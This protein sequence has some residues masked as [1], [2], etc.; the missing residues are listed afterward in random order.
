MII[1]KDGNDFKIKAE[2]STH[3][4]WNEHD[5]SSIEF[6]K[7]K[8]DFVKVEKVSN[9][10]DIKKKSLLSENSLYYTSSEFIIPKMFRSTWNIPSN[11]KT[12]TLPI[13]DQTQDFTVDWGDGSELSNSLSHEYEEEGTYEVI[14]TGDGLFGF[15]PFNTTHNS[16]LVSIEDWGDIKVHN[17]G[18]QFY[19][20]SNLVDLGNIDVSHVTN[21]S[22]M[23]IYS[24]SF[25][26][27]LSSWDVSNVTNMQSMFQVA[28]S[29]NSDISD[30]DVSN[31][32]SMSRMFF[33][34]TSFN[35]DISNWDVS[36][37]NDM[38]YMFQGAKSFDSDISDWNVSN[39]TRMSFMFYYATSFNRDI[40][41][42]NV[43]NV[44]GMSY[45]FSGATS[46]N[47]DIG[48]WDVSK[49]TN[50]Q[51]MFSSASNFNQD[52][53]GW[54]V[55]NVTIMSQMFQGATSFNRDISDWNVSNV[56]DM[57]NMLNEVTLSTDN[58][59]SLLISWSQQDVQPNVNFHGGNSKYSSASENAR[60]ILVDKG[61]TINDGGK[62]S[63]TFVSTWSIQENDLSLIL[64]ITN[65]TQ[66][67]TVDWGD[68]SEPDT[69]KGHMYVEEGVYEVRVTGEGLFGFSASN[70]THNSKLVSIEDWGDIKVHNNGYQFYKCSN[71]VDVG[72]VDISNLTNM[73]RMFDRAT[74]FNQDISS[75]DVSNVTSMSRMF[76][77]ATNFNQ[78]LSGWDVSNVTS[79]QSMFSG[80]TSFNQD[81]NSWNVSKVTSMSEMFYKATSFNSDIS[82]WDVSKVIYMSNMFNG[83]TSFNQDLS[84][85]N[86]GNVT[87]MSFMFNGAT[88]FNQDISGWDVSKV[89]SMSNMFQGV[90]LSTANYDSLLIGW[91]QQ[92]V[93]LNVN[94]DGGNSKYSSAS[95]NARQVLV[96]KGWTI[97]DGGLQE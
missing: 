53:S 10:S 20:C 58:Y 93:K 76:I 42:W 60:Q 82:N 49:V 91:S 15:D 81:L 47:Q 34:A 5:E 80:A 30:W 39:V 24:P 97:T 19:K 8:S 52:I 59:D 87:S 27:D 68:G 48:S 77:R 83:A 2:L 41:D 85:W 55:S 29:F 32:T 66:D 67:F 28:T 70:T 45:M 88:S 73:T 33:S 79:M 63:S 56:T 62:A 11:D 35:Q 78:D 3:K 69:S 23:F 95:V 92:D 9:I 26:Q 13:T 94:F 14:V 40:S 44:T 36:N 7:N 1:Q 90:T 61:W 86:V 25:N 57:G 54:D 16:K 75:W 71:L 72:E 46:F 17:N 51:S 65:Q 84:D 96:D 21:M 38:S 6:I 31:V 22:Y 37:V 74:S 12:L 43:S 18:Y 50:M 4:N 64:P 89:T